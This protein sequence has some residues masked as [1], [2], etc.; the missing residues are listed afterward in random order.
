MARP[1]K[2]TVDYF[3]FYCEEGK[4]MYY[5][6]ETY[7]NDGFA[8]FVKIL[9]ELAKVDYHYLDLS[10]KSSMMFLSSKCKVSIEL[11]ESIINDLVMLEKFDEVLWNEN[12]IIWCQSFVDSIQDAYVKRSNEC[13]TYKSLL[14]L[15]EGLG[16]RKPNKLPLKPSKGGSEV[17]VNTQTILKDTILDKIK[18]KKK[19]VPPSFD[20]FLNYARDKATERSIYLDEAK[21]KAKF[22]SWLEND[23]SDL[24][25]TKILNWKSKITSN[26]NYWQGEKPTPKINPAYPPFEKP[27]M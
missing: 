26:V 11:L 4:K 14:L 15:L 21:V 1:Q 12:K 18:E 27:A 13:I 10:K 19:G 9:R 25:G 20:E 8:T 6:E 2:N 5:I 23:W 16:I 24:N 22:Y 7:G 3:P 17:S